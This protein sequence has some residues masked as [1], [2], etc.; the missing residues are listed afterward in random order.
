MDWIAQ[1]KS[2]WRAVVNFTMKFWFTRKVRNL[3]TSR[4]I[5]VFTRPCLQNNGKGKYHPGTG[6][7]GSEGWY[8]YNLLFFTLGARC[9]MWSTLGPDRFNPGKEPVPT[10]QNAIWAPVP[11]W[12]GAENL[13]R[14]EIRSPNHPGCSESLYRLRYPGPLCKRN[15]VR[16]KQ[17]NREPAVTANFLTTLSPFATEFGPY[18]KLQ[19]H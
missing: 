11:V 5:F 18:L 8:R 6:H 19:A 15:G 10:V 12:T 4:I 9:G 13:T 3:L 17:I 1:G 14:T 2:Q 16:N 7:E